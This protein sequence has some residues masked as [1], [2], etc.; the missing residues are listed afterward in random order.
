MD[1]HIPEPPAK[2]AS[3]LTLA[4]LANRWRKPVAYVRHLL[5]Q[6]A[7][8]IVLVNRPPTE[9]VRV[10]DILQFENSLRTQKEKQATT[11]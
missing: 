1:I 11:P 8:P 2:K 3:G 9:G 10:V 6:A 5:K 4:Q 7:I